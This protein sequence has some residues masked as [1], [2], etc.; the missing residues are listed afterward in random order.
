[1]NLMHSQERHTVRWNEKQ[2]GGGEEKD[3]TKLKVFKNEKKLY[4]KSLLFK[5]F[6]LV[7]G[8]R[9]NLQALEFFLKNL[10]TPTIL[11]TV[12]ALL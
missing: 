5:K 1:M 2:K 10:L 3:K 6:K 4:Y 7:S 8:S 9:Q 11:S 12:H